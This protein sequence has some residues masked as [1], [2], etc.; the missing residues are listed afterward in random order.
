MKTKEIKKTFNET[1]KLID[2]LVESN[3]KYKKISHQAIDLCRDMLGQQK[4]WIWIDTI[5]KILLFIVGI[6]LGVFIALGG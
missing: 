4:R 2:N 6:Q 3:E 5:L 1:T